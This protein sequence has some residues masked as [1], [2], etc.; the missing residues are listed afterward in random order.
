MT[1]G[2]RGLA[3]IAVF[4]ALAYALALASAYIPNV[5]FIY[6]VIFAA[7]VLFGPWSGL[8]VGAIGEFLWTVFNPLGPAMLPIMAAQIAAMMI[9]GACGGFLHGS[10][11]VQK[12]R[13]RGFV[14]LALWGLTCGLIFQ[15]ILNAASAFLFGPFWE[16][17]IA[18]LTFSIATILSNA[19][20]FPVCYPLVVKLAARERAS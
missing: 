2:V 17:L 3:R 13:G 4:S 9:I 16:M 11:I 6:I 19:L 12:V 7:G 10:A 5:S 15:I 8:A 14:F 1:E 18:G 20:I